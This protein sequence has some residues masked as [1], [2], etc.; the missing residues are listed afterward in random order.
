MFWYDRPDLVLYQ[1]PY[2]DLEECTASPR[3]SQ[4]TG[5]R[6]YVNWCPRS[7]LYQIKKE[8]TRMANVPQVCWRVHWYPSWS[9]LILRI[10]PSA[11]AG[12]VLALV[13]LPHWC[14]HWDVYE[15]NFP[16][17]NACGNRWA[18]VR[19]FVVP[20]EGQL[21][22]TFHHA[23]VWFLKRTPRGPGVYKVW[24]CLVLR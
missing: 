24:P 15:W 23:V 2:N 22:T 17:W 10:L 9:P 8:H 16:A 5:Y 7:R 11:S 13:R 19:N 21:V 20:I 14:A 12:G 18:I 3:K 6:I 1:R 4:R